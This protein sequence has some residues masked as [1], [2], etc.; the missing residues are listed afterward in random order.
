M[1]ADFIPWTKGELVEYTILLHLM[2]CQMLGAKPD[3]R[4]V[5]GL[6]YVDHLLTELSEGRDIVDGI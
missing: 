6:E 3:E 4:L 2:Q 5:A 1:T